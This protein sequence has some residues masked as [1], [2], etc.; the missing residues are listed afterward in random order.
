MASKKFSELPPQ[1][2]GIILA[3]IPLLLAAVIFYDFVSPL[4]GKAASLQ[5]QVTTLHTQNLRGR[6]LMAQRAD[7]EKRIA[8]A[9]KQLDDLRQIVP[10]QPADDQFIKTVYGVAAD[11]GVHVRSMEAE[12]PV[13][14]TYYTEMPFRMRLDGT[15]YSML[16]FFTRLASSSRIVNVRDL[17]LGSVNGP[18][19]KGTYKVGALETVAADCTLTTFYNSP[20]PPVAAKG[21]AGRK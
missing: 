9:R 4:R 11:S 14:Q 7:L 2:Q 17:A 18:R 10:D 20:P 21:Q 1:Q 13:R 5:E 16:T 6:A 12:P 19:G 3:C 15:Y 8:D